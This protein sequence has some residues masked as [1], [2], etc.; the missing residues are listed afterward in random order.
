MKKRLLI[1]L[2]ILLLTGTITSCGNAIPVMNEEQQELVIEYAVSE[3]LKHDKNYENKLMDLADVQEMEEAAAKALLEATPEPVL[4]PTPDPATLD[5]D[6]FNDKQV[7]ADDI[8]IVEN[9][10]TSI[11][12]ILNLE[13]VQFTYTGY[14]TVDTYPNE[15]GELVFAMNA[16]EG[17][18]LLVVKFVAENI[19][20]SDVDLDIGSIGA[21]FKIEV[22]GES[23]NALTNMLL[24]DLAY[25]KGVITAGESTELVLVSEVPKSEVVSSLNLIVKNVDDTATISLN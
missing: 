15:T 21:R 11:E 5:E 23:K 20:A 19:S 18:S 22:N 14:E 6:P 16:T 10:F 3:V 1:G 9:T 7:D 17:N 8:V 12:S 13:D 4:E 2:G 25:Y 24:N